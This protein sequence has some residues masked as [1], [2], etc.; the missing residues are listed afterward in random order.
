MSYQQDELA[1]LNHRLDHKLEEWRKLHRMSGR[2][3]YACLN[4]LPLLFIIPIVAFIYRRDILCH[5]HYV[6]AWITLLIPTLLLFVLYLTKW[7]VLG[8]LLDKGYGLKNGITAEPSGSSSKDIAPSDHVSP[9]SVFLALLKT[10]KKP[11][12][13]NNLHI[14]SIILVLITL[15]AEVGLLVGMAYIHEKTCLNVIVGLLLL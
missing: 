13:F 10:E 3:A 1:W 5:F 14:T 12:P 11:F 9:Q 6:A 15:V 8:S 2:I 4:I 7:N